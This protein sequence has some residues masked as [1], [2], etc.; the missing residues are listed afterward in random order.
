[1]FHREAPQDAA[2]R[3]KD[4]SLPVNSESNPES[5]EEAKP[6][7][8][9]RFGFTRWGI[10]VQ[11]RSSEKQHRISGTRK[12][13]SKPKALRPKSPPPGQASTAPVLSDSLP[14]VQEVWFAGCH[15]D[16]G[17]GAVED[18]VRYSLADISLRWMVKEVVL[19]QCGIRFDDE[20]LRR[21]DVDV[22]TIM[23][24][25]PTQPNVEIISEVE[26]GPVLPTPLASPGSPGEDGSG[27]HMLRKGKNKDVE[28]LDW[29][30]E[31]DVLTDT[32]DELKIQRMWWL[33]E[34]LP[35]KFTWQ[36]ADGTWKSKW[37]CALMKSYTIL[38]DLHA[39][40]QSQLW[41][42]STN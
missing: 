4:P 7:P 38:T 40:H 39:L 41:P 2:K 31:Q 23:L 5:G 20:A 42:R 29:P 22:S 12:S 24:V 35:M 18:A 30:Q 27:E 37:G 13:P 6:H 10:A 8:R 21:A 26:A 33:L 15:S 17:G 28:E 36:A 9:P 32:H 19:S 34:M 14:P 11:R 3:K 25:S 16:V 1:M